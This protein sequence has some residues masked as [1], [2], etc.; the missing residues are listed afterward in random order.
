MSN[1]GYYIEVEVDSKIELF[2]SGSFPEKIA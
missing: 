2:T 1:E